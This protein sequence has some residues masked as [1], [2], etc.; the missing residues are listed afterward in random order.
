MENDKKEEKKD[1]LLCKRD[2]WFIIVTL[3][4][5]IGLI[6]LVAGLVRRHE[7]TEWIGLEAWLSY[8][9]SICGAIFGGCITATGLYITFKINAN[10]LKEQRKID[11]ERWENSNKQFNQQMKIQIINEKINDYKLCIKL[12]NEIKISNNKLITL[13]KTYNEK[14]EIFK[15]NLRENSNVDDEDIEHIMHK[16]II[17]TFTLSEISKSWNENNIIFESMETTFQ[18]ISDSKILNEL[19]CITKCNKDI[20]NL[21]S[22]MIKFNFDYSINKLADQVINIRKKKYSTLL[23][24]SDI[25]NIIL[26]FIKKICE[27]E[28][29]FMEHVIG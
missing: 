15:E 8:Y 13:V 19:D 17:E 2:I 14:V 23:E 12:I 28:D 3:L 22:K 25:N 16:E 10:Q 5:S 9:G 21:Y 27:E 1:K 4:G 6:F 26:E 7:G 11:N 24:E 20:H 18:C 29:F